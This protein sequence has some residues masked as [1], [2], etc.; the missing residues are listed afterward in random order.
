MAY[1]VRT[2]LSAMMFVF[3]FGVGAWVVTLSTYLMSAP[4]KGG[5]NFSTNQVGLIYSAFAFGGI[6]GV[7]DQR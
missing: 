6:R 4:I 5:L 3:Y 1:L 2:R 7:R